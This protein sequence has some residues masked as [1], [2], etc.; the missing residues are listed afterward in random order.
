MHITV[1]VLEIPTLENPVDRIDTLNDKSEGL[2]W[3][4]SKIKQLDYELKICIL[5]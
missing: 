4:R 3:P 2:L 1:H 5:W